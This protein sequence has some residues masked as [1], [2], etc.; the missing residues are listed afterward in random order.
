MASAPASLFAPLV[1]LMVLAQDKPVQCFD[2]D[3]FYLAAKKASG[4]DL[5]MMT[6][7]TIQYNENE[8]ILTRMI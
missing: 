6:K 3:L 2:L 1:N 5:H 4:F 7:G 8:D